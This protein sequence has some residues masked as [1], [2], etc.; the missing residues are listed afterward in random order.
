MKEKKYGLIGCPRTYNVLHFP[1]TEKP[2][3]STAYET[4][5]GRLLESSEHASASTRHEQVRGIGRWS[6]ALPAE[7]RNPRPCASPRGSSG[8]TGANQSRAGARNSREGGEP[9]EPHS[10]Q[11][12]RTASS[13][14]PP[15]PQK[16]TQ[17]ECGRQSERRG[18]ESQGKAATG[19]GMPPA[20]PRARRA[21]TARRVAE[22]QRLVEGVQTGRVP[23]SEAEKT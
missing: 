6:A 5:N 8:E 4:Q 7:A 12:L 1:K 22:P 23:V 14:R 11:L 18:R 10:A 16:A 2:L 19:G 3:I 13:A 15:V 17:K 9:R 21:R 20:A